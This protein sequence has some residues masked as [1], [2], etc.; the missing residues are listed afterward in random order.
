M[1]FITFRISFI[2]D[3]LANHSHYT[4]LDEQPVSNLVTLM[5]RKT[6]HWKDVFEAISRQVAGSNIGSEYF[7]HSYAY[8]LSLSEHC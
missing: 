1:L 6:K 7:L 8:Y 3:C 2:Q 5:L 4:V